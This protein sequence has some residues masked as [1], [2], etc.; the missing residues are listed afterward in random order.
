MVSATVSWPQTLELLLNGG[1]LV[2]DQ[3]AALMR[4]WLSEELTPVQTG[5]FLAAIRARGV[6][7][8]ELGAMAAVLREACPLPGARPDLLMVDTCGTGGDGADTFNISTA[9]AFTAAACGANVAKHGNRSVSSLCGSADVLEALGVAVDLGPEGV[10]ECVRQC[11]MGFMF[12]PRYHPSMKAVA[13]VRKKLK[14]RTAFNLLGPMLNPASS[15]HA[16]VGVYTPELMPLMADSL[17]L[18][19]MKKALVVCSTVGDLS[20][21]EMT[22]CGP[23]NVM[24]VTPGGVKT[25][26]FCLLYTSPSPRD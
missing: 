20:L 1:V 4:A 24:E 16:L 14:V 19:G 22:P 15:K 2:P 17:M 8:G 21:D 3:A 13:P 25:Y 11:G 10:A 7:G 18:L 23:T 12:A 9:V 26:S 5:A 6:N